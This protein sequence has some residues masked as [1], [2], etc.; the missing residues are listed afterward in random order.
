MAKTIGELRKIIEELPDDMEVAGRGHFG[1]KLE[2]EYI[3]AGVVSVEVQD[4]AGPVGTEFPRVLVINM[5]PAG[6][7][8]E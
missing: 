3:E 6:E 1:E 4:D 2:C 8:P 7:E 5:E